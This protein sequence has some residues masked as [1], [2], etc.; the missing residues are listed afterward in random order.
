MRVLICGGGV[1]G[2][3]IAY[4]L[5]RRRYRHH[6]AWRLVG[7]RYRSDSRGIGCPS[8]AI[9]LNQSLMRTRP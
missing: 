4:F 9:D 6:H 5:S 8:A 1:I 7:L 3:S 2:A